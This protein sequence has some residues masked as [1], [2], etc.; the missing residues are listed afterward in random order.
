MLLVGGLKV[1]RPQ[2][3]MEL[4]LAQIVLLGMVPQPGQLQPEIRF[5]VSQVDDDKAAVGGLFPLANRLQS[6]SLLVKRQRLVQVG[7]VEIKMIE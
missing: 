4:T 3:Q 5:F 7:Y 2:G 1:L 6:Q